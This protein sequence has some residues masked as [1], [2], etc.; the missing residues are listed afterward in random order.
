MPALRSATRSTRRSSSQ[1]LELLHP[2]AAA[3]G[4]RRALEHLYVAR[5][6]RSGRSRGDPPHP[7]LYGGPADGQAAGRLHRRPAARA[8]PRHRHRRV[9]L[10]RRAHRPAPFYPPN[11]AGWDDTRWLDTAT[12]RGR[13]RVADYAA[14]PHALDRQAAGRARAPTPTALVAARARLLGRP[15]ARRRRARRSSTSRARDRRAERRLEARSYRCLP[16]NALRLLVAVSPDLQT[17]ETPWPAA[18]TTSRAPSCCAGRRPGRPRAAGDRARDAAA[19]RHRALPAL[20][21]CRARPAS[22]W[23][24]TAPALLPRAFDEGIAAAAAAGPQTV[25]VSVFLAGGADSLSV[26]SPDG[27]PLY[28]KL[29]PTPRAA[30]RGTAARS[31]RT[32]GCAGTRRRRGSRSCTARA[33]SP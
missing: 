33:R 2:G 16:Q 23:P 26:L 5:A 20:A 29:R 4:T 19:R 6:T 9:G 8:R 7:A 3:A 1:A 28:R 25:L 24:S 13:W 12:F 11:V 14:E 15:G 32:P 22:R 21:S 31:A 30:R 17:S 18:A 27:D 10:A